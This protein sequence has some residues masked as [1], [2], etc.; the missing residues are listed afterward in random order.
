MLDIVPTGRILGATVYGLD[1]SQA[2]AD[3]AFDQILRALG[4]YGVLRF[5]D[6]ALKPAAQKAF[7]SRFGSLEVHVA[8]IGQDPEHPEIM[9]LSNIVENGKPIGLADAGQ[10]WHTD[11]SYSRVIALANVLHAI[12]VP[13]DESG[14][15]LGST[16]FAT[17]HAAYD[18]L[19]AELKA[20]LKNATAV[21][22]FN[23]FWEMMRR[24]SGSKRAPLTPQ[25]RAAKPLVSHPV[26]LSHPITGRKVLYADPGY[27]VRINDMDAVE[28]HEILS[29]LFA[30]QLQPRYCYKH[31]WSEGDLMMWDNIGTLH[32]AIADY[33][34]HQPRLMQRCQVMADWIF[35]HPVE[36]V[37]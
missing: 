20:R 24:R 7:A 13:R 33:G 2:L 1:L 25:Q 29:F 26:F 12:K 4:R 30:H 14:H 23:K 5:P 11:M 10:G 35:Q 34:P 27:T 37:A 22:D 8:G 32:N 6:Q 3:A 15:P 17:M 18:D 16:Q 21:H 28:S 31:Q 36:G 9:F 19:A